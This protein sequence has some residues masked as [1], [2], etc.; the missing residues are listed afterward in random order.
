M[1]NITVK[2]R[3]IG[4]QFHEDIQVPA[5]NATLKGLMDAARAQFKFDY[6]QAVDGTMATASYLL[7]TPTRSISSGLLYPA[8]LYSLTDGVA[9]KNSVTTWQWYLLRN[10]AQVN[11]PDCKTNPF[12]NEKLI[13]QNDDKVI[14]RLLVV[15]GR[16]PEKLDTSNF[17]NKEAR[18][19]TETSNVPSV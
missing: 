18:L 5:D 9:G 6:M 1:A 3:V 15:S 10:N 4:I 13:L 14:W 16:N 19:P 2:L 7:E 17:K 12:A 8:G 11:E